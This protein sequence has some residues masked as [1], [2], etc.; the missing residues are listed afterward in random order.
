MD[1]SVYSH[2]LPGKLELRTSGKLPIIIT[3]ELGSIG[4]NH[5]LKMEREFLFFTLR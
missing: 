1:R 5:W 4:S 2:L 3:E